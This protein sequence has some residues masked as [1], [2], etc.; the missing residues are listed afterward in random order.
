MNQEIKLGD[1]VK[2]KVPM[3][4]SPVMVVDGLDLK[5]GIVMCVWYSPT[6]KK[7]ERENFSPESLIV[8]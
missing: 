6:A 1:K 5:Q 4:G 3:P 8:C 2:L 7:F